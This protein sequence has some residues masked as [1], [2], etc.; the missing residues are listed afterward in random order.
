MPGDASPTLVFTGPPFDLR[1]PAICAR[2]AAPAQA[3]LTW[4]K[5]FEITDSEDT[6]SYV[7]VTARAPFCPACIAQHEREVKRITP[8]GRIL[9]CF[10]SELILPAL[11]SG[12]FTLFLAPK[13]LPNLLDPWPHNALAAAILGFFALISIGSFRAAWD[14]TDR[15]AVPPLTSVTAAFGF[16][17]DISASFEGVRHRYTLANQIFADA[18]L[19]ANQDRTWHR[20]SPQA[21]LAQRKRTVLYVVLGSVVA[22]ALLWD[23]MEPFVSAWIH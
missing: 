10:R 23:W 1:L 15:R 6:S 14:Q 2:C 18:L 22:I 4:R 17:R 3:N 21:R 5:V 7:I 20:S 19:A 9:L 13:L 11:F 16:S 8:F 12:G